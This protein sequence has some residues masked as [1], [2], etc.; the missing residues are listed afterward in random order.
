LTWRGRYYEIWQR[1]EGLESSVIGHLG[2]GNALDPTAV[3]DCGDVRR[4]AR[5]AGVGSR[6]T[7]ARRPGTLTIPLNRTSHPR[8]WQWAGYPGTL[9]PVTPRTLRAQVSVPHPDRYEIWLGGSVRGGVAIAV[10]GRQVADVRRQLNNQGEYVLLGAARLG[11]GRHELAIRFHGADL[12]PGSGGT[13]SPVGP[14]QLAA[15]DAADARVLRLGTAVTPR[16]CEGRWDWI[17]ALAP[18]GTSAD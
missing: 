17:E 6:L 12:H 11:A 3:P 15:G 7:A 13:P 5:R 8:A 18:G 16:L 2:L 10:D 14:L 1:P 9:L 4:L